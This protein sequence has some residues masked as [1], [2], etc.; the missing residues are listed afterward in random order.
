MATTTGQNALSVTAEVIFA[1][2]RGV[3]FRE[4]TNQDGS[5]AVYIGPA[6]TVTT[7]TGHLLGA[8]KSFSMEGEAARRAWY[9]IAASGTPTITTI[10]W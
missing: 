1:A 9:A 8:G 7:S 3:T 4:V 10:E 2:N 5:I 6:D